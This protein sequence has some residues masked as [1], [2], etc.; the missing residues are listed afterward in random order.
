MVR[1][2]RKDQLIPGQIVL[3]GK[4]SV[5]KAFVQRRV[6]LAEPPF[7]RIIMYL[8]AWQ[9]PFLLLPFL[10]SPPFLR[11]TMV[12]IHHYIQQITNKKR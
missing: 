9:N 2:P 8:Y 12:I 10:M 5:G 6:C 7:H 11:A 4:H 3:Q 1:E